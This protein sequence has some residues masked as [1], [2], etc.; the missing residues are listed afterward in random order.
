MPNKR[1]ATK[2]S[3]ASAMPK[4]RAA[5]KKIDAW[6]FY[7]PHAQIRGLPKMQERFGAD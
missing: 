6:R 1:A 5:P 2:K 7:Q 4:E 3:D